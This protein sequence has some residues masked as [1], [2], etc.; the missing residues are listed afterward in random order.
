MPNM[1]YTDI[2]FIL[3]RSGSMS[4]RRDETINGFNT[5][6]EDQ[7]KEQGRAVVSLIQFD[8]KYESYE[9]PDALAFSGV[10]INQVPKLTREK[11]VPRG[12]TALRMAICRAIDETGKRLADMPEHTRPGKVLFVIMTDGMENASYLAGPMYG[13]EQTRSRITHQQDVYSWNFMYIG[14][15]QDAVLAGRSYGINAGN[16]MNYGSSKAECTSAFAALSSGVKSYRGK[17]DTARDMGIAADAVMCSTDGSLKTMN[18]HLA[19]TPAAQPESN[20]Q[21]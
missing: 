12:S 21:A 6:I 1:Q 4:E 13:P 14:T 19:S 3:D 5:F 7:K 8:D 2:T 16:T 17:F 18:A 20:N 10:D 15:N 11:F 9:T